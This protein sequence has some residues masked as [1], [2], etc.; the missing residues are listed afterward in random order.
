MDGFKC[1]RSIALRAVALGCDKAS[2]LEG[3][4]KEL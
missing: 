2:F 4:P 3:I 1:T